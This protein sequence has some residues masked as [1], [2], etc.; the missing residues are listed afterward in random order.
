MA[1]YL[2]AAWFAILAGWLTLTMDKR[3]EEGAKWLADNFGPGDDDRAV[4]RSVEWLWVCAALLCA[5]VLAWA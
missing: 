4:A 5:V 2:L 1:R 3:A